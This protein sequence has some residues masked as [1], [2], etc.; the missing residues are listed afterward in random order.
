MASDEVK[1]K[2]GVK[3]AC[4][5]PGSV[6]EHEVVFVLPTAVITMKVHVGFSNSEV[7]EEIMQVADDFTCFCSPSQVTPKRPHFRG[8]RKYIGP[9]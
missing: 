7:A 3:H 1:A 8:V 2:C 5:S 6:P 4:N 9:G